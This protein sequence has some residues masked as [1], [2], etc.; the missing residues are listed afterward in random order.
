MH[1]KTIQKL[2]DK[3]NKIKEESL[4]LE[5]AA[6]NMK[7]QKEGEHFKLLYTGFTL[8]FIPIICQY[9]KNCT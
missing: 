6:E 1:L 5:Q 3:E 9:F 4:S 7:N 2:K 8:F